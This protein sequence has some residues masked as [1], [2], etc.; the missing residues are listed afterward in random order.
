MTLEWNERLLILDLKAE[1]RHDVYRSGRESHS[2]CAE[3][4]EG[5]YAREGGS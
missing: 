1:I 2:C 5:E 4:E 3:R